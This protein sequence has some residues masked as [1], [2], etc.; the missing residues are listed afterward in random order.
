MKILLCQ[1][2]VY[3]PALGGSI[4][5]NRELLEMLAARGHECHA[6][7]PATGRACP[8]SP[9]RF[10]DYLAERRIAA[11]PSGDGMECFDLTGVRVHVAADIFRLKACLGRLIRKLEPFWIVVQDETPG[12]L[13]LEAALQPAAEKVLC[14]VR[15]ISRLPF[16]PD[17][18][19]PSARAARVFGQAER[20]VCTSRFAEE[21]LVKW[22]P[23]SS[24]VAPRVARWPLPVITMDASPHPKLAGFQHGYVTLINPCAVKGIGIFLEL[25]RRHRELPFAAVP[26]WG[27]T[28]KDYEQLRQLPNVTL[29]PQAENIDDIF[30]QTRTLLVPSLWPETYGRTVV[31]AMLRGIPVLAANVGGLPEAKCGVD[32]VLPVRAITRYEAQSDGL[33]NPVPVV[34]PQ[35]IGPWDDALGR[36]LSNRRLYG[37]LSE[38][39]QIAARQLVSRTGIADFEEWLLNLPRALPRPGEAPAQAIPHEPDND[40][41]FS[42]RL[43]ALSPTKRALFVSLMARRLRQQKRAGQTNGSLVAI[44]PQGSRPILFCF[45]PHN[46]GVQCYCRLAELLGPEQPVFGVQSRGLAGDA[47]PGPTIKEMAQGYLEDI[48]LAQPDGP[49]YLVGY[50][51]GGLIA[52]EAACQLE[53]LKQPPGLVFLINT[54]APSQSIYRP[55]VGRWQRGRIQWGRRI[56]DHLG[57]LQLLHGRAKLN[58]L[59]LKAARAV[60]KT[61]RAFGGGG[62]G[63]RDEARSQERSP[64]TRRFEQVQSAILRAGRAY[65]PPAYSG[66]V[67]LFQCQTTF[68]SFSIP[69][70]K[71][72]NEAIRDLKVHVLPVVFGNL[73]MDPRIRYLADALA[74]YLSAPGGILSA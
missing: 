11:H 63:I 57:A 4:R 40:C 42:R 56:V 69:S 66:R 52:Y 62:S 26:T 2:N 15:T 27:T 34:P 28:P 33:H 13:L 25:A 65:R 64:S 71:Q 31:E 74:G 51:S 49:Y 32:F 19:C 37:Q 72:G 24:P 41:G 12:Q 46:G 6:A 1:S 14:L 9:H 8:D 35:D 10:R 54:V 18:A 39:S 38:T 43:G 53:R 47:I 29:L 73:L 48:R 17:S 67:I 55:G 20:I 44:Q 5:G 16:G 60:R 50:C 59:A 22:G 21:Y 61:R 45:H 23:F 58:Y 68:G 7:V 30:S 70:L 36:L 3:A